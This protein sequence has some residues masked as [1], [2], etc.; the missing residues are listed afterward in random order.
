MNDSHPEPAPPEASDPLHLHP[1]EDVAALEREDLEDKYLD[2][3]DEVWRLRRQL[4]L[5]LKLRPLR[6]G[7]AGD[8]E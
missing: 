1:D 8:H 2:L 5:D 4:N 7:I 3:K 6:F